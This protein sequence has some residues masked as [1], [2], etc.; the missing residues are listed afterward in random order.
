MLVPYA[1]I[2]KYICHV[3]KDGWDS[4]E[5]AA[6]VRTQL[7]R[8]EWNESDLARKLGRSPSTVNRWMRGDRRPDTESCDLIAD[9]LGVDVDLVLSLV[10]HRPAPIPLRTSD[11]QAEINALLGRVKLTPDRAAGLKATLGAWLE[12]DRSMCAGAG[13]GR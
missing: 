11:P 13:P 7:R 5:F 4:L 2:V 8:R 6:W 12:L 9:V 1:T 10:G 3:A